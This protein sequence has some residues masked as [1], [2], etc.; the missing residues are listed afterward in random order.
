[1]TSVIQNKP[2]ERWHWS[3]FNVGGRLIGLMFGVISVRAFAAGVIHLVY[4]ERVDGYPSDPVTAA[5]VSLALGTMCGLFALG[6]LT[7]RPFRPDLGDAIWTVG[8]R[9]K[10]SRASSL[11]RSWWTGNP[12]D[13]VESNRCRD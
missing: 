5:Y 8:R 1:V 11:R 13:D 6:M 7:S 2:Y 10:A 9:T 12:T 3:L 4:R